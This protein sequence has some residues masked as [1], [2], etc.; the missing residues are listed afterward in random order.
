MP[1]T[2]KVFDTPLYDSFFTTTLPTEFWEYGNKL[3]FRIREYTDKDESVVCTAN[4]IG[5]KFYVVY[6]VTGY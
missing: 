3:K 6:D 1:F 2:I 4:L 5:A